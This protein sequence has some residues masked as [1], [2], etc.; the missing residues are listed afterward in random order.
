MASIRTRRPAKVEDVLER[1]RACL[2]AGR[3]RDTRHAGERKE[4]RRITLL[5][6]GEVIESG[7]REK[8]KDEYKP[9]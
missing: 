2:E 7:C 4:E 5:E 8:A 3:Y 1:S 6:V 9:E